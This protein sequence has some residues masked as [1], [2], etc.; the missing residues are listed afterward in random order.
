MN[1]NNNKRSGAQTII[2]VV[3]L[4][5]FAA[6]V[7]L[8]YHIAFESPFSRDYLSFLTLSVTIVLAGGA[9]LGGG[10]IWLASRTKEAADSAEDQINRVTKSAEERINQV[11]NTTKGQISQVDDELKGLQ[12]R[13]EE[14]L[15]ALELQTKHYKLIGSAY[16]TFHPTGLSLASA[17]RNL[18]TRVDLSECEEACARA[19]LAFIE[20]LARE[21]K[22]NALIG[23]QVLRL[24]LSLDPSEV[25]SSAMALA[26]QGDE[27]AKKLLH[28]RLELERQMPEPDPDLIAF[29]A[30]SI[31]IFSSSRQ[32]AFYHFAQSG[33]GGEKR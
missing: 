24:F 13:A 7:Y 30:E 1:E 8:G 6:I 15:R 18:S 22:H 27:E 29:L 12:G 4:L 19:I 25:K 28:R 16:G 10:S 5:C 9:L 31:G 2:V 20:G 3:I 21:I 17:I 23:A 33:K 26:A 11:A 14:I 32:T